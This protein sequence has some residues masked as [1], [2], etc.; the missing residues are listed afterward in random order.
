MKRHEELVATSAD[1]DSKSVQVLL[2][3]DENYLCVLANGK[4]SMYIVKTGRLVGQLCENGR[5]REDIN[6]I[7]KRTDKDKSDENDLVYCLAQSCIISFN[8]ITGTV[9]SQVI[10]PEFLQLPP[11][12]SNLVKVLVT[13]KS[14]EF[15]YQPDRIYCA[16]KQDVNTVKEENKSTDGKQVVTKKRRKGDCFVTGYTFHKKK[17]YKFGQVNQVIKNVLFGANSNLVVKVADTVVGKKG[18]NLLFFTPEGLCLDTHTV[19]KDRPITCLSMHPTELVVASGDKSGKIFVWRNSNDD[20]NRFFSTQMHWHSLPVRALAWTN[21]IFSD[22]KHLYSGGEEGAIL[23]WD[24]RSARRVGIV[25]RIGCTIA[26][27][28][29]D[30]G[31]VVAV[32]SNNSLKL[33]STT[34]EDIASIV[35]LAQRKSVGDTR[36]TNS[37]QSDDNID[38]EKFF[39]LTNKTGIWKLNYLQEKSRTKLFYHNGIQAVALLN[40]SKNQ[41]QLFDP[42]LKTE[43]LALDVSSYNT[44]LGDRPTEEDG[45]LVDEVPKSSKITLFTLSQC[46]TWLV[47][48]ESN[49]DT[50]GGQCTKIWHFTSPSNSMGEGKF[51]LNTQINED[52]SSQIFSAEF[53]IIPNFLYKV[54]SRTNGLITCGSDKKSKA[55]A[56]VK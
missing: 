40:G 3:K 24:T 11:F 19:P 56:F 30:S 33:F 14:P 46:G 38:L 35:G 12:D 34:F 32:N 13:F 28:S 45:F 55:V 9:V 2:C 39:E 26:H 8:P 17:G 21:N 41:I 22:S 23:K 7:W 37:K 52:I 29:A 1:F 48:V 53:L 49:Y 20:P 54:S 44:I 6:F 16:I 10:H 31:T 25:P 43:K 15:G 36:K 18:T 4:V 42:I 51:T 50:L 5:P 47:T 27:I